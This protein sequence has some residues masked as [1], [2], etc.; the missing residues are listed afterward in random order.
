[1]IYPRKFPRRCFSSHGGR[2]HIAGE[3]L[4][5]TNVVVSRCN[6][7]QS[8]AIARYTAWEDDPYDLCKTCERLDAKDRGCKLM[9]QI[10]E[11][12]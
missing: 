7:V 8:N 12:E 3:I 2:F 1:M 5:N 10:E 4:R 11:G 9:E 6:Q